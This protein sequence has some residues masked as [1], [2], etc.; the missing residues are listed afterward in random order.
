MSLN[1]VMDRASAFSILRFSRFYILKP[2]NRRLFSA[3]PDDLSPETS[4]RAR[5]RISKI[6]SKFPR[7]L[8]RYATPLID[9]P[10]TH[11][12]SFLLLHEL[13]AIVP[14]FALAATFHYTNW[15]PPYVSEGKWVEES[16]RKF[17]NYFR[18]KGWLGEERTTRRHIWW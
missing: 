8:H 9:A 7:F 16:I 14:L 3:K 4:Q 5:S 2:R 1:K 17:G 15:L 6:N 11:I 10:L 18:K 13:T 12:T